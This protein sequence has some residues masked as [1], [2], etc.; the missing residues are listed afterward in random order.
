MENLLEKWHDY[1]VAD[2]ESLYE[3]L[4]DR[5]KFNNYPL[6]VRQL[7]HSV[8]KV[9]EEEIPPAP[10]PTLPSDEEPRKTLP[11]QE[12]PSMNPSEKWKRATVKKESGL[13]AIIEQASRM[14]R[15]QRP[16]TFIFEESEEEL[17]RCK[18]PSRRTQV[19]IDPSKRLTLGHD[20]FSQMKNQT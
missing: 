11:S 8:A 9:F 14:S 18:R 20:R 17:T 12:A 13:M 7:E 5:T 4:C 2:T 6:E 10:L 1:M 3:K 15:S 19:F 16:S